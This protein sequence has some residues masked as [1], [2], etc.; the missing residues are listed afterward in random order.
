[1]NVRT[2]LKSHSTAAE[3]SATLDTDS[4]ADL[5]WRL[6]N[7][8]A[9]SDNATEDGRRHV[10][11]VHRMVVSDAAAVSD[12]APDATTLVQRLR[13][14]LK[15]D[16]AAT[17]CSAMAVD[18]LRF[19]AL[20]C[21]PQG[22]LAGCLLQEAANPSV[23]HEAL[24]AKLHG[25]HAWHVGQGPL[26]PGQPALYRHLL[27]A[28]EVRLPAVSSQHLF[29]HAEIL[30]SSWDLPAYRL[31][32]AQHSQARC[33]EMLG[34][35]L[36]DL[37]VALPGPLQRAVDAGAL[38][39]AKYVAARLGDARLR[40]LD[41]AQQAIRMAWNAPVGTDL[42]GSSLS[43]GQSVALGFM[44]SLHL[45][46]RWERDVQA[47]M[48]GGHIGPWQ[49]MV[50]LVQRKGRYAVGYH[51]RQTLVRQPFDDLI[52]RDPQGFVRALAQSRW[53]SPGQPDESLL[54]TKLLR[55]GGPMFRV[56]ADDETTV[57]RQWIAALPLEDDAQGE[58]LAS[59]PAARCASP[60]VGRHRSFVKNAVASKPAAPRELYHRLLNIE[61]HADARADALVYAQTWLARSA[62]GVRQSSRA[63]PFEDYAHERLRHWFEGRALAQAQSYAGKPKDIEKSREDV[64]DEAV[65]LC[66]MIFVDGAWLQHWTRAGLV[67]TPVGALLYKIYSDEIGNGL[68]E[69]NHPAIYRKLMRQMGIEMPDFRTREFTR[70]SRFDE[71]AFD[72]PAFWLSVS[73]FPRR[74]LPET[75]GLNLA[76][77]LSGV[78]GAY[79]TARDELRN[80]GYDT[81]FVDL[82]NTIDNASTGH[83]ALALQAI[84]LHMDPFVTACNPPEIRSQWQRVWVGFCA[85]ASPKQSWT[86]VFKRPRYGT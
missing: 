68:V 19:V 76:M 31:G 47:H 53:V 64:V 59:G 52:V 40:M 27:E 7:A 74:F 63:M 50:R 54:L 82:H 6:L 21:A 29:D 30:S 80:Y 45:S 10:Q 14:H 2:E 24:S 79:R 60:S 9:S 8:E 72:V 58:G 22:L 17:H 36:F 4:P 67:D 33:H 51:G 65:Q 3:G 42:H 23:C 41:Q 32:L 56:F 18:E 46:Q 25:I 73:Q 1:M 44:A 81:L 39:G 85:L 77:E 13:T 55:F 35:A 49:S 16:A 26:S 78:G 12:D 84:E 62:A 61:G 69:L 15:T 11:S 38:V 57:I 5:C 20:Q 37:S 66:P 75:L 28:V 83:S 48:R 34:A 43:A 86:E 70:F 71:T